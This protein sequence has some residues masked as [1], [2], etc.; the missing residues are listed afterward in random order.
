M[1]NRESLS[2]PHPTTHWRLIAVVVSAVWSAV[3]VAEE[4]A[5]PLRLADVVRMAR[6]Q[7]A[8][9]AAAVARAEAAAE[10]PAIVGALEDPMISPS[11]DHYPFDMMDDE[12]ANG[13][14]DWSF[15]IEQRFPL[16]GIREQNRRVARADARR[17]AAD[18]DRVRLDVTLEAQRAFFMVKERREMILVLEQQ[19][20]LARELVM[21]ASARYAG[22]TGMQADVLRAEVE[23]AR[24]QAERRS[25]TAEVSAAEAML[26]VTLGRPASTAVPELAYELRSDAPPAADNVRLAAI[27]G[28][29]ELRAGEAEVER[30]AAEVEV[31]RGMY[32]PMASVRVGRASTMAEGD[33]AM[34]MV[35]ISVP[36]WRGRL[37]AGVAEARSMER[38]ARAD[39][40][41]MTR[42]IEGEAVAAREDVNATRVRSAALREDVVPRARMAVDA[43]LAGYSAGGGTLVSV[44]ESSRA[45]WDVRSEQVMADSELAQAWA[46]LERATAES[47]GADR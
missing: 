37:R 10:R 12:E 15:S 25:F 31:M 36:I 2:D 43:A 29:P 47:D 32:R 26:N 17:A 35:G 22:G 14:Y 7:R 23:V 11:V 27:E 18:V 24:A 34:L 9:V 6:E 41:A 8:E 40:L 39:L 20:A 1:H 5:T 16:S 21:A 38:M 3:A 13:R 30:G 28:R 46:R 4:I 42:M 44:I 19:L 45:L 33:G